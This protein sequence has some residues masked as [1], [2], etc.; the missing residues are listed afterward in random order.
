MAIVMAAIPT[1]AGT[2]EVTATDVAATTAEVTATEVT[3]ATAEVT[4]ATT[5]TATT[6]TMATAAATTTR[7]AETGRCE[8][9]RPGKE[10][11]AAVKEHFP[12]HG[13]ASFV[14]LFRVAYIFVS[15]PVACL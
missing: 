7:L 4:A 2:P 13:R 14:E 15:S 12:K 5:V 1:A 10:Q 11:R 6:A 8:S 9:H 3:T